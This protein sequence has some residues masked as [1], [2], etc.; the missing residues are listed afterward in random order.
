MMLNLTPVPGEVAELH[1]TKKKIKHLILT[2][3]D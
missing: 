2:F 3:R 1:G